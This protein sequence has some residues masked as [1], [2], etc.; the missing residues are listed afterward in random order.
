MKEATV[1]KWF[2]K[3]IRLRDCWDNF[4]SVRNGLINCTMGYCCTCGKPVTIHDGIEWNPNAH[5]GH[6]ITRDC[7]STRF[8]EKNAHLQ[9]SHCNTF[10]S[11][12][13]FEHSLFIDKKYGS[14]TAEKILI[15]SKQLCKR[16]RYDLEVLAKYY[17]L[18]AQKLAKEKGIKL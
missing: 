5:A 11:G 12:K 4:D 6:F 18:E 3:F 13:Q 15:K 1:D 10:K 7:K 14:G 2:S 16:N 9:C 17:R 8:D